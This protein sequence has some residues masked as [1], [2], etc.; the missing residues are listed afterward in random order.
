MLAGKRV[1]AAA[2]GLYAIELGEG[3]PLLFL[4]GVT[5]GSTR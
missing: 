1:Q 5:Q 4:H 2:A 3:P